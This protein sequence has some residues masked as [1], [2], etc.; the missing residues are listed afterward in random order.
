[1]PSKKETKIT[2]KYGDSIVIESYP[3]VMHNEDRVQ[4][5]MDSER[6]YIRDLIEEHDV[7]V[8]L[9][10]VEFIEHLKRLLAIYDTTLNGYWHL[11][12]TEK[13]I[14]EAHRKGAEIEISY[15]SP[16]GLTKDE[17]FENVEKFGEVVV[18]TNDEETVDWFGNPIHLG[19]RAT[20]FYKR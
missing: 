1:M 16:Q 8:D 12:T 7:K 6:Q 15:Y 20:A 14:I 13:N 17:A 2:D 3:H 18:K 10:K 5:S 19:V 4:I 11:N 9:S